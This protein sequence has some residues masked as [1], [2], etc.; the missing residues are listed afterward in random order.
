[1][2]TLV[3][4]VLIVLVTILAIIATVRSRKSK[5]SYSTAKRTIELSK[6]RQDISLKDFGD[7]YTECHVDTA[8][9]SPGLLHDASM[10]CNALKDFGSTPVIHFEDFRVKPMPSDWLYVNLDVTN[11]NRDVNGVLKMPNMLVCK[12]L[13]TYNKLKSMT[14]PNRV[15][16]TGFT[17]VDRYDASYTK[18][19]RS[20]IHLAGKSPAKGTEAVIEAWI[21]N[22]QWPKLT[23]VCR[24]YPMRVVDEILGDVLYD[25]IDVYKTH[26]SES[27][28]SKMVNVNGIHICPSR[29]EGFGHYANEA[30]SVKA[31]TLYTDHT[32]LNEYFEDGVTGIIV[33][34]ESDGSTNN[35]MCPINRTYA[36]DIEQAV[37][38]TLRLSVEQLE[39]M[40]E[41]ARKAFLS[42]RVKFKQRLQ[43]LVRGPKTIPKIIHQMWI[44]K[45]TPYRNVD[46]PEKYI[47]YIESL[48][49]H[50][51]DFEMMYW[52]GADVLALIKEHYPQYLSFYKQL[53]P[54]ISKC[55]F[56]RFVILAVHGGL[57]IDLDMY[58]R[59]SIISLVASSLYLV[60]EPVEHGVLLSN[61]F[62][63]SIPNHPFIT[64]WI[65]QMSVNTG[66]VMN[67]TGPTGLYKYYTTF[68]GSFRL[69][70]TCQILSMIDT[71]ATASE[72]K[73][74]YDTL[75]V[76]VWN[77][78]SDWGGDTSKRSLVKLETVKNPITGDDMSWESS[79]FTKANFPGLEYDVPEKKKV[80]EI[81]SRIPLNFGVIDVGAH[82]GDLAIPL[83][84]ALT[85]IGREDVTVYAI[86][87][88]QEKCDFIER[89]ALINTL[90]NVT[91]INYG[92]YDR[93]ATLGHNA[94]GDGNTGA[95]VWSEGEYVNDKKSTGDEHTRFI[96][97]DDLVKRGKIGN[98]GLY[99]IDVEGHEIQVN[100]GSVDM[101]KRDMPILLIESWISKGVKCTSISDC[102]ELFGVL[103]SLNPPYE[104]SDVMPNDDL[105]CTPIRNA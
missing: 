10:V 8:S 3:L 84:Q 83:A 72:C 33:A 91:V 101:I 26:V 1:M 81:A 32:P 5:A 12:T 86:D 30:R 40:G 45:D 56:G 25:N 63:G 62:V 105:V 44:G 75:A 49:Y 15:A 22:P 17:S 21:R 58:C 9:K 54:V 76:T 34:C 36:V 59:K 7:A 69:G 96:R 102:P 57:Y 100:E 74:H 51:P 79:V 46:V 2:I 70:K 78:G 47:K 6:L 82:I 24:D 93:E 50:N 19:Y 35:G 73:G 92:L 85:S 71:G 61:A 11:F 16:Y 20:F 67:K 52:S 39:R 53:T 87:P 42:D 4:I 18:D 37:N 29:Y 90:S 23:V 97:L 31:V 99:H 28:L 104:A 41:L 89:M 48:K 68:V 66:G 65:H 43:N 98:V 64:G 80:F 38:K 88:S 103:G 95:Q 13:F 60:K 77:D 14:N 27:D 94:I 55:D